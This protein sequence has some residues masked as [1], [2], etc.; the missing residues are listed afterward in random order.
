M[1]AQLFPCP[2]PTDT[3]KNTQQL[4]GDANEET[5]S[6]HT[7]RVQKMFSEMK[8][9]PVQC[10]QSSWLIFVCLR[11]TYGSTQFIP[12]APP[13]VSFPET[14]RRDQSSHVNSPLRRFAVRF[15]E[16]PS[17]PVALHRTLLLSW[18]DRTLQRRSVD[19]HAMH[20]CALP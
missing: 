6:K 8:P 7:T 12:S 15:S 11:N 2:T 5:I 17:C 9:T 14:S 19:S 4:A 1:T 3:F 16:L 13:P 18:F 10:S 20:V